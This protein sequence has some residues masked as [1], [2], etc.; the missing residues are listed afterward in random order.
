MAD[1]VSVWDRLFEY[2]E[3]HDIGFWQLIG[4]IAVVSVAVRLPAILK[5]A[6]IWWNE[7]HRINRESEHKQ[8][9]LRNRIESAAKRKRPQGDKT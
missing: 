4:A 6:G 1:E 9:Q 7:R 8:A 5:E 2:A 3:K